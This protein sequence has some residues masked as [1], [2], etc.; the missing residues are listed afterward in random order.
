MRRRAGSERS[1]GSRPYHVWMPDRVSVDDHIAAGRAALS[2]GDWPDARACFSAALAERDSPGA[3]EGLSWS[4]WWLDD[5]EACFDARTRAYHGYRDIGDE[6]AAA[7]MAL[8]LGDDNIEFLGAHAVARGWF[9]R[10]ARLLDAL[11]ACPEH[12]WLAVFEAHDA[13]GRGD[14]DD[15]WRRAEQARELGGRLRSLDLEMFAV[16]TEGAILIE[17]GEIAEGQERL[18]EAATAAVAGEFENLAPAAWSCCLVMSTC[19]RVRD[20]ER[21]AQWC[22]QIERFSQRMRARFLRGVCRAHLGA[23]QA[24]HG[25][26][27]QA[28]RELTE[29]LDELTEKRPTWRREAV[30]RLG[31]LRLLQGHLDDADRLLG[32]AAE[33]PLA[34]VGMAAV[35][36]DRDDRATARDLIDRSLR[37]AAAGGPAARVDALELRV[38]LE[39]A[40]GEP[41]VARRWLDELRAVADRLPAQPITATLRELEGLIVAGELDHE[42]AC[43]HLEDAIDAFMA[44]DAP[45]EAARVRLALAS[46]LLDFGRPDGARREAH[47][48]LDDLRDVGASVQCARAD[49]LL[50]RI[51]ASDPRPSG[52]DRLLTDRQVDVLRLVADGLSDR[53]IADRLVLSPHTVHRHVAN[54]YARLGCSSRAAAVA[55]AGRRGLL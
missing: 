6:R 28:E 30:V 14:L 9:A 51:D 20:H 27:D 22:C 13:L 16:A 7:R 49:A 21:A 47:Q 25:R 2:L 39:L 55:E 5:V 10:A 38:R 40:S 36:L 46:S 45:V 50:A 43:D 42:R 11:R 37:R 29:A 44:M 12:G 18:D 35:S 34:L 41:A 23:L 8:W 17:R 19:E 32:E 15:A 54:V 31:K 3:L 1:P 26:W 24:W 33:H 4:A 48:A 53:E 52:R